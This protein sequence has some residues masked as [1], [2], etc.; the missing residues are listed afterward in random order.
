MKNRNVILKAAVASALLAM[1]GAA[2]AS[3]ST[4]NRIFAVE[5]FL[6]STP[7]ATAPLSAP[8]SYQFSG[9]V[10]AATVF[11]VYVGLSGGATWSAAPAITTLVGAASDNTPIDSVGGAGGAVSAPTISNDS[12]FVRF[13]VTLAAGK[14]LSSISVFSFTPNVT[15]LKADTALAT[16]GGT[17]SATWANNSSASTVTMPAGDIDA[18]GTH[19]GVIAT[20]AQG[21]SLTAA[22]SSAF[23]FNSG[24]VAETAKINLGAIPIST[25]FTQPGA[26][27]SNANSTTV[28]T[29]GAFRAT[30]GTAKSATNAA[31]DLA[32]NV[33]TMGYTVSAPAGFFAALPTAGG[34]IYLS[35]ANTCGST[36]GGSASAA[37]TGAAAATA[38][39]VSVTGIATVA[40]ATN[41][42]IC[43]TVN[44]S[45]AQVTGTPSAVIRLTHN[46][47]TTDAHNTTASTPMYALTN[48]G[49]SVDVRNYVP[50]AVTGWTTNLRIINTGAV[51]AAVSAAAID[52]TSGVVGTAGVLSTSLASGAA[53]TLSPT[54]IEA[55]IGTQAATSRPR[56]RITAPT[57]S[58]SVQ[59][60][61]F[62][63]NGN[64][65][66]IH[67]E[68]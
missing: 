58:L 2:N 18:T 21:I 34:G 29:L 32:T 8:I 65:S 33:A 15:L 26:S 48:N 37:I 25:L 50:M 39:S 49:S 11:Y 41:Q 1:G 4:Q 22:A 9:P 42:Y 64:F 28:L 60:Y 59:T 17:I 38:T 23:P 54:L 57:N 51:A 40:S 66:I 56:I 16:I 55:A 27:L 20:S 61:V 52:E 47:S 3:I 43:M 44:G 5:Q 30:N 13:T 53:I 46:T 24:G 68:E 12:T 19:T 35:A 63:P 36:V 7:A 10:A 45:T 62:N 14:A 67:G 6:G 31:Y